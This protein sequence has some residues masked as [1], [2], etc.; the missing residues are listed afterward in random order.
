MRLRDAVK[1]VGINCRQCIF[2]RGRQITQVKLGHR[3][4]EAAIDILRWIKR[5][6]ATS[7]SEALLPLLLL[8][9]NVGQ[10]KVSGA[11]I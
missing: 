7:Q 1:M 11:I 4:V 8:R 9:S 10:A 5:E 2:L 3:T 6:C